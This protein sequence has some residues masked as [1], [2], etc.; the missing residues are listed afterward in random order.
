[1]C[2][3]RLKC[4]APLCSLR[5]V[6]DL[7]NEPPDDGDCA[8]AG[9]A[10]QR[11]VLPEC[12]VLL[13]NA[14]AVALDGE[15]IYAAPRVSCGGRFWLLVSAFAVGTRPSWACLPDN[16]LEMSFS[17]GCSGC[18]DIAHQTRPTLDCSMSVLRAI[19]GPETCNYA[20]VRA[21]S[22]CL[23]V[24]SYQRPAATLVFE[25]LA[26]ARALIIVQSAHL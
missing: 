13:Y 8:V 6:A 15:S 24:V 2:S 18:D 23:Q 10:G 22:A 21:D 1:M 14:P 19:M 26:R 7:Q 20:C 17:A 12:G 9:P 4:A 11:C 5:A 16:V 25:L 3:P